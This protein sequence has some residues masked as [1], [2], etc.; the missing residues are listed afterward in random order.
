MTFWPD[1]R[2]VPYDL[3]QRSIDF[4]YQIPNPCKVQRVP[5]LDSSPGSNGFQPGPQHDRACER[6]D[7]QAETA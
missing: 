7:M 5:T 4:A 2:R 6:I 1:Q 3:S